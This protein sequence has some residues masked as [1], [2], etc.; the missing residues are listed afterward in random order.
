MSLRHDT[1][2]T[3]RHSAHVPASIATWV[4]YKHNQDPAVPM[5]IPA[6]HTIGVVTVL[7][8]R[9]DVAP[10]ARFRSDKDILIHGYVSWLGKSSMEVSVDVAQIDA[11]HVPV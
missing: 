1:R 6:H 7:V 9:I 10:G 11:D 8:D 2:G 3:G 4:G 5:G